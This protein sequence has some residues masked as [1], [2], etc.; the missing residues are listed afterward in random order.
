[1]IPVVIP[2]SDCLQKLFQLQYVRISKIT[3]CLVAK[4]CCKSGRPFPWKKVNLD[5][6]SCEISDL[7]GPKFKLKERVCDT[8]PSVSAYIKQESWAITKMTA[9]CSLYMGALKI[10]GSCRLRSRLLFSKNYRKPQ[11]KTNWKLTE[12]SPNLKLGLQFL[13]LFCNYHNP[14]AVMKHNTVILNCYS[15]WH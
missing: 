10:S 9:R 11:P 12:N 15:R 2:Y 5:T 8:N 1:M 4:R 3:V 7:I 14:T 13:V 6:H